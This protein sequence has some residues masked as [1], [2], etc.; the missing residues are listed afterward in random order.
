MRR[1]YEAS[2]I[3]VE[4]GLLAKMYD[5]TKRKHC[6]AWVGGKF[7]PL[8]ITAS[9]VVDSRFA[10]ISSISTPQKIF[11]PIP[12]DAYQFSHQ[13]LNKLV[14]KK[15]LKR[16]A[17]TINTENQQEGYELEDQSR[18]TKQA[19]LE[20][21]PVPNKTV[22]NQENGNVEKQLQ[23][24]TKQINFSDEPLFNFTPLVENDLFMDWDKRLDDLSIFPK[25]SLEWSSFPLDCGTTIETSL[26][27]FIMD[28]S[29]ELIL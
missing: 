12:K 18:I 15:P 19:H 1:M 26:P 2:N 10:P 9:E 8:P 24:T 20:K 16:K 28:Y 6:I 27:S 22:N 29:G 3:L 14:I 25:Q 13:S 23:K 4:F 17:E 7:Y 5:L 21:K 11:L